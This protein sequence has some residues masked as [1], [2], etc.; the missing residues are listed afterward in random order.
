MTNILANLTEQQSS[1]KAQDAQVWL[2][3]FKIFG[4]YLCA[5]LSAFLAYYFAIRRESTSRRKQFVGLMIGLKS[6]LARLPDAQEIGG[7]PIHD[8]FA[9]SERIVRVEGAKASFDICK[10]RRTQFE[11]ACADYYEMEQRAAERGNAMLLHRIQHGTDSA[12]GGPADPRSHKQQLMDALSMI[13]EH[14][15]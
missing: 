11:A 6:D 15:R 1:H 3:W 9:A 12:Y 2:E 10:R 7:G 8:F 13:V 5:C 4:P 14:A